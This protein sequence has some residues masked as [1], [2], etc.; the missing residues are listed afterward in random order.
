MRFL[1]ALTLLVPLVAVAP[2]G[3]QTLPPNSI[4]CT[5][6]Q[7]VSGSWTEI[8]T[9]TFDLGAAQNVQMANTIIAPHQRGVGG[10]DLSDV[11][12]AKCGAG[13]TP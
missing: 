5:Q 6:F 1:S 13:A 11:L 7:Q 10:Y 8:G 4:D 9:A 2:A 12:N 3:A